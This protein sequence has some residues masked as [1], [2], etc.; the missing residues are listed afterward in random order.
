LEP[1]FVAQFFNELGPQW[2]LLDPDGNEH[3]ILFNKSLTQPQL[4][5]GWEDMRQ[6][7]NWTGNK[8]IAFSYYGNN[9]FQINILQGHYEPSTF[10]SYHSLSS[11]VCHDC[12]F[13]VFLNENNTTSNEM[14]STYIFKYIFKINFSITT[15]SHFSFQVLYDD[16]ATFLAQMNYQQVQ[17][18]GPLNNIIPCTLLISNENHLTVKFGNGWTTF[19]Q[20]NQIQTGDILE[21]KCNPIMDTNF[22]IVSQV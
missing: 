17:L 16:F 5:E 22:I 18:C 7:Y 9:S 8:K 1:F 19:C 15:K 12:C 11:A 6:F 13:E 10:P 2:Q 20:L 4:T 21:F 3:K 14:V